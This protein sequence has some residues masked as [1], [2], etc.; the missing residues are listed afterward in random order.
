MNGMKIL[1]LDP[2]DSAEVGPWAGQHWDRILDIGFGGAKTYVRWRELFRCPVTSINSLRNTVEDF[3]RVRGLQDLG[4]G[5]LI[6]EY[7]LD[8]WEIMSILL[9]E[10][11]Q[12]VLLIRRFAATL[13]ASDEVHVT[14]PGLHASVLQHLRPERVRIF[15]VRRSARKN[16]LG[17]YSRVLK[18]LSVSQITD[19]F[20]DKYD[21]GYQFRGRFS[22]R[23]QSSKRPVVLLPTAYINVSRTGLAY[24]RT[25]PDEKFLLVT[26]RQSG[27]MKD[28]PPN[29]AAARLSSYAAVQARSDQYED[30]EREWETLL[31]EMA[32]GAEF[33]IL[34]RLGILDNFSRQFRCSLQVRDAWRNMFDREPVEAV[35]CADDSNH[36]TRIP[37]LL[38][39]ERGLANIA[40]H[41]GALDGL[42][43]FKRSCAD[44]IWAKGKMEADYLVRQCGVPAEKVE[45]AAPALAENWNAPAATDRITFR[46]NL[47]F[48]SESYEVTGA[49]AEGCYSDMLPQLA[50]LAL[51]TGRKLIVKLHPAESAAQRSDLVNRIL[52][53]EQKSVTEILTGPLTEKLLSTAWFGITILSTVAVECAIRGIPCFLCK[54]LE[55]WPYQYVEQF[56]RYGAGIGLNHPSEIEKIPE[57]L[58]GYSI[59]GDVK[60]NCWQPAPA[61]RLLEILAAARAPLT[62]TAQAS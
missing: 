60:A 25:F 47:L 15:Q 16:G 32:A 11:L 12:A 14:R 61:A 37:L 58:K 34:K 31:D 27:W 7:G 21:S 20:W 18:K 3:R 2:L 5:K 53:V 10:E 4:C 13:E 22:R 44:T 8:W 29:V 42:Y 50:N 46:P 54:W 28:L 38:A 6:D 30:I 43:R 59:G 39:R 23:P 9:L 17:H 1:L 52:T 56:I 57:Y 26:T 36:T 33:E 40:C 19:V 49:R 41:H 35:L 51:A 55:S 62:A 45:I 48:I 24:A